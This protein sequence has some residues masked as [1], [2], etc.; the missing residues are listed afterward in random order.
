VTALDAKL[1]KDL[2]RLRWQALAIALVLA[3]ASATFIMSQGVHASLTHA[4]DAYYARNG[5]ADLFVLAVRAPHSVVS[6]IAAIPGV[7]HAE[8]RIQHFAALDMPGTDAPVGALF[9][10]VDE[11]GR[12]RLNRLTLRQGSLPRADQP[13]DVVVDEAFASA[14]RLAPG[15]HVSALIHGRR[16][17]L[18]VVGVGIAPDFVYALGPGDILPDEMRFGV[19]WMGREA[20][21]TATDRADAVNSLSV[22]LSRDADEADVI[23]AIDALLA[24]YGGTGAYGRADQLSHAFLDNELQQLAAITRVIPP[25]FL[26]VSA[27][28]VYIVIGRM[29]AT[30]RSQIGLLKAFGY[31]DLAIAGHYLKFALVIALLATLIGSAAGIWMGRA[32]ARLYGQ[33]YHFPSLDYVVSPLLLLAA[34]ALSILTAGLGA[35]GSVRSAAALSPAVAMSPPP[36]PAYRAG[37]VERLGRL[38]DLSAT[39]HMIVRHI[40]R[41]P[42]RS[43]ITVLGVALA[44]GLLFATLQ[45]IDASRTMIDSYFFRAQRQDMTVT[46]VEPRGDDVLHALA[47]LPGVLRVEPARRLPVRLVNGPRA[48]RTAIERVDAQSSLSLRIDTGGSIIPVPEGGLLLSRQ[49]ADRL[50]VGPGDWVQVEMLGGRRSSVRLPVARIVDEY[51]GMRAYGTPATLAALARDEGPVDAAL[52]R[53]DPASRD[54]LLARL[55]QMPQVLGVSEKSAGIARFEAMIDDNLLT[56]IG[57]YVGLAGAIVVGVV[58]N[59]A[60]IIHSERAHELATLRVLGYFR[61]EVGV[62]L[63][64][65][66]ALLVLLALP[67]ACLFGFGLAWVMTALFSSDLFRLPFSPD[68]ASYGWSTVTVLLAAAATAATVARRVRTLDMVRV[69]KARE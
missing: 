21:E 47:R 18:R 3:A 9:N 43:A 67:L 64:G 14:H 65:E 7:Q 5:F 8:G 19:F 50:D 51:I 1:L 58:Y 60:R 55:K 20:L 24:P 12:D 69:L 26:I 28:L 53:I 63:L 41:W 34:A 62:V 11:G 44:G 25:V 23:R 29:V 13:L 48:E 54:V 31:S 40:A 39:G 6:R 27:F 49:L 38:L 61:S 35:A 46:F 10:G 16:Q 52:L 36:P 68:A 4:R 17:D 32:M 59:S 33:Y 37:W 56:M 66:L 30:E 57:F 15:Q 2:A 45:F 42:G 22:R